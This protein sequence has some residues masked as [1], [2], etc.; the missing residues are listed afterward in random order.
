[1]LKMKINSFENTNRLFDLQ[2][3]IMPSAKDAD[4]LI[5]ACLLKTG[6]SGCLA[7]E[8]ARRTRG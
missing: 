1:M 7:R 3:T 6:S 8:A 4:R 2:R 5:D